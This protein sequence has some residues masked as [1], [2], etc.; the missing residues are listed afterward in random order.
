MTNKFIGILGWVVAIM[1][2]VV[3]LINMAT[4]NEYKDTIAIYQRVTKI[5][6]TTIE[7]YKRTVESYETMLGIKRK[8][9]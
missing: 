8:E 5:N 1:F 6:Q 3:F 4:I 7:I 2:F 9:M